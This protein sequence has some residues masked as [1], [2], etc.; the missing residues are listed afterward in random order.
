MPV[1]YGR[2][3]VNGVVS[4]LLPEVDITTDPSVLLEAL[5]EDLTRPLAPLTTSELN[6]VI[7][8]TRDAMAQH[9]TG[10]DV[11][12]LCTQ[13]AVVQAAMDELHQRAEVARVGRALTGGA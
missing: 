4:D 9:E 6:A 8:R 2:D 13:Q 3:G 7:T 10:M 12:H 5:A 11:V 1:F